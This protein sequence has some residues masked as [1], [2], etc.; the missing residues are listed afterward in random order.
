MMINLNFVSSWLKLCYFPLFYFD[1]QSQSFNI[2]CFLFNYRPLTLLF[3]RPIHTLLAYFESVHQFFLQNFL[4][5][6]LLNYLPANLYLENL[7]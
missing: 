5:L 1:K 7:D 6:S 3:Y 4:L 2:F